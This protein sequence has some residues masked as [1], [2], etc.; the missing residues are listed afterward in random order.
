MSELPL[1]NNNYTQ[2]LGSCIS[3]ATA[4]AGSLEVLGKVSSGPLE[5]W[6]KPQFGQPSTLDDFLGR[7]PQIPRVCEI[8]VQIVA[9]SSLLCQT[10]AVRHLNG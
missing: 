5:D 3:Q 7:C 9:F 2:A 8:V 4:Q 6:I 10:V 1:V